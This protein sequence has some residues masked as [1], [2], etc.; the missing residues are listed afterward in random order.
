[1]R[2]L[3]SGGCKNGK[4]SL[5]EAWIAAVA[6]ASPD[7]PLYYLATMRP[8]DAEDEARILRHQ[9]QR[10]DIPFQTIEVPDQILQ[11]LDRCDHQGQ[12]LLDSTTAL[13]ENAMFLPEGSV[14]LTAGAK[15]GADL[16]EL[17]GKLT[18]ITIVSDYLGSDAFFYDPLTEAFRSQL[19]QIDRLVAQVCDGV[20]E[21]CAGLPIIHKGQEKLAA[22]AAWQALKEGS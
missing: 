13:L 12:F 15:I 5:A 16:Q 3:V 11:V 10:Q 4:S 18:D 20:I 9:R 6:A 14:D 21:V 2:L 8:K 17:L 7:Q 1:M 19:A 22:A